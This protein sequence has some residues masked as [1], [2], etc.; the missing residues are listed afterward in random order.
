MTKRMLIMLGC[1]LLL[2]AVLA[3][4]FFLHVRTLIANAPKPS[5][6]TV[7]TTKAQT[8]EWQ[9]LRES[10]GTVLAVRGVDVT[11]EIAGLVRSLNFKSGQDVKVGAVLLQLNADSDI[12]QLRSLQ[13]AA[14]LSATTLKRDQQQLAAQAVAQA[15]V[16]N[17]MAD[18]KSR[19]ALVAQQQALV[20]KKTIRAPF[21]GRV[22]ITT[23]NP[24][25]YLNP[26]DKIVTL[27]TVDP[28][29][30]DFSL[31]QSSLSGIVVGQVV[32]VAAD[33]YPG[34]GFPG[35]IT[36]INPKVDPTT[37]NM[38]IEGDCAQFQ[39]PV[40]AGH[41]R[42]R[43]RRGRRQAALPDPAADRDHLQ[44]LRFDRV[45]PGACRQQAA[46]GRGLWRFRT[47]AR[48]RG[49]GGAAGLGRVRLGPG[50]AADLR[51]HR[52]HAWRPG[53]DPQGHPGGAGGR[54]QRPAQAEERH[55]VVVDNSV[56]PANSPNPTPQEK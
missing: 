8:L 38:L 37:R 32:N 56:Q 19:R 33:A 35:K 44:P 6:Q 1:V 51:H 17:D 4:G 11:T 14:D 53:R 20:D 36:A 43:Q 25:Q 18:L 47:S 29:Y 27:Q 45:H 28:V 42:A 55:T 10:V 49:R 12:A 26:G 31:P 41:V 2:V 48:E 40:A 54:H 39:G 46:P 22:G 9:P 30:I 3:G 52:R 16:D 7:S 15:T 13:A 24:G 5:A 50:G 23:V 21:S 34:V